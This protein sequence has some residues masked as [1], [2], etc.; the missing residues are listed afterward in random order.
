VL[1]A[2]HTFQSPPPDGAKGAS[3]RKLTT[4]AYALTRSGTISVTWGS[5]GYE[6]G[7]LGYPISNETCGLA[8]GVC[9]QIFQKGTITWS[10]DRGITVTS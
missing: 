4:E 5:L 9:Q 7:K 2:E 3:P 10:P 1:P 8:D 6:K